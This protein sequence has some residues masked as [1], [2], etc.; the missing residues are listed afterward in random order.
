ML[1]HPDPRHPT[2]PAPVGRAGAVRVVVLWRS[3]LPY[4]MDR[5]R[6]LTA[7][8]TRFGIEAIGLE[9]TATDPDYAFLA[10]AADPSLRLE[11][12]FPG[13]SLDDLTASAVRAALWLAFARLDPDAIF[14]PATPFAEGMAAI[15]WARRHG[16]RV[17]LMDDAWEATDRRGALVTG[18]KT[19][20]HGCINGVLVPDSVYRS[21]WRRLGVPGNRVVPGLDVVDN[22][23]FRRPESHAPGGSTFLYVGRDLPRKGLDTLLA[24]YSLY[25]ERCG[26]RPWTLAVIGP[27]RPRPAAGV[28]YAGA[29]NGRALLAELWNAGALVVPS[30]FE[31]W[32]LVVNEAM[33]A[34]LPVLATT[35]VGAARVLIEPGKT[36]WLAAPNDPLGLAARLAEIASLTEPAR[37]LIARNALAAI[38]RHFPL[39]AFAEGVAQALALPPRGRAT[40]AAKTAALLWRGRTR[41]A[42]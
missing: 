14:A 31:Q 41:L 1:A 9:V 21:Y 16:R 5:L 30:D 17:F 37:S 11:T 25:R 18:I 12:C 39:R 28:R 34:G 2:E 42:A 7:R 20:I 13:R 26:E 24:A 27:V 15:T 8:Q 36:G 22:E 38:H 3:Y 23:R 35:T 6:D 29:L 40:L 10:R 4:S 19:L 32:G 33:A